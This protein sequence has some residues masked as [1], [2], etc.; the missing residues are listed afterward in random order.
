MRTPYGRDRAAPWT[1]RSGDHD[2][3]RHSLALR[4]LLC[5]LLLL[6]GPLSAQDTTATSSLPDTAPASAPATA[7]Q[8]PADAQAEADT[9]T[10]SIVVVSG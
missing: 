1:H 7:A 6:A 9:G 10:L 8:T 5:G 4:L 3:T 2:V